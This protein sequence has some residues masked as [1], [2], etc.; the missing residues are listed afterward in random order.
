M[1]LQ[2]PLLLIIALFSIF[3]G[4]FFESTIINEY[5]RN[6]IFYSYTIK[7]LFLSIFPLLILTLKE[8]TKFNFNYYDHSLIIIFLS[9]LFTLFI[10]DFIN[11]TFLDYFPLSYLFLL[12]KIVSILSTFIFFLIYS[13]SHQS[14]IRNLTYIY[15]FPVYYISITGIIVFILLMLGL[16]DPNEWRELAVNFKKFSE[17]DAYDYFENQEDKNLRGF[18][19][20]PYYLSLITAGDNQASFFGYNFSRMSGVFFEPHVAAFIITPAFFLSRLMGHNFLSYIILVFLFM[21][22]SI[23][24]IA[25]LIFL[26]F[27]YLIKNLNYFILT[28]FSL[29]LAIS[30]F[31]ILNINLYDSF[32]FIIEKF[33]SESFLESLSYYNFISP[34]KTLF[35]QYIF[36]TRDMDIDNNSIFVKLIILMLVFITV[37]YGSAKYLLTPIDYTK[38]FPLIYVML[39]SL[40]L[41]ENLIFYYFFWYIFILSIFLFVENVNLFNKGEKKAN[42]N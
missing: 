31:F 42:Y 2:N 4:I 28:I 1:I 11:I 32:S 21:C 15:L 33:T 17:G 18:Y 39:H 41:I 12:I 38:I 23:T 30:F 5:L 40:K 6:S 35:G 7:L 24:N 8:Q 16:I 26:F 27:L 36:S 19:S 14:F 3:F 10:I 20:F 25:I 13:D 34:D 9:F 37:I 22:A 29:I